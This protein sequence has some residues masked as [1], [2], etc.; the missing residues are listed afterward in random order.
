MTRTIRFIACVAVL[1]GVFAVSA[2]AGAPSSGTFIYLAGFPGGEEQL[3]TPDNAL[4]TIGYGNIV[5]A[6]AFPGPGECCANGYV[7]ILMAPPAGRSLE[8]G[9]FPATSHL[10]DPEQGWLRVSLTYGASASCSGGTVTIDSVTLRGGVLLALDASWQQGCSFGFGPVAGRLRLEAP[11]DVN[12]PTLLLPGNLTLEAPD[13]TIG[14]PVTYSVAVRDDSD[15][16]PELLCDPASDS[17]FL[18]GTTT[19]TCTATDYTGKSTSGSFR[20]IV[21]APLGLNV[22][23]REKGSV[24]SRSGLATLTGTVTCTRQ[25]T[26]LLYGSLRQLIA[27]RVEL[28][29]EFSVAVT[30]SPPQSEWT[31]EVVASNGRFKAGKAYAA[32]TAFNCDFHCHSSDASAAVRLVEAR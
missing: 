14:T 28:Q 11:S 8:P 24:D 19:V 7:H 1:A 26:I 13:D 31:V 16:S 5:E 18:I 27:A 10:G 15:P 22:S 12:P 30:C 21:L 9:S 20:V 23:L 32:V 2:H 29:G 17:F 4:V 3:Y 6:W 25:A